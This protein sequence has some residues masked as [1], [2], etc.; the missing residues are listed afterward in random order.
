MEATSISKPLARLISHQGYVTTG[1]W[2]SDGGHVLSGSQDTTIKM[3]DVSDW[4]KPSLTLTGHDNTIS[5]IAAH[6]S[7]PN[8][9]CSCTLIY[10][11]WTLASLD[12]TIRLWDTR[13]SSFMVE[14]VICFKS[15]WMFFMD[16]RREFHSYPM[17]DITHQFWLVVV[18]TV[19]WNSGI[20]KRCNVNSRSTRTM[21]WTTS[22]RVQKM[23]CCVCLL[24]THRP[25]RS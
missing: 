3:W 20:L 17:I 1:E 2:T 18:M 24:R 16:M 21:W 15:S 13:T 19:R 10:S 6:P 14:L 8:M 23:I 25:C 12:K 5:S 11:F 7:N 9:F 4:T 22:V